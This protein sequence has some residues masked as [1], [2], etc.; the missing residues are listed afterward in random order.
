MKYRG[1]AMIIRTK[2][3][4]MLLLLTGKED[5]AEN[6]LMWKVNSTKKM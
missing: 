6:W 2:S 5:N 4:K 3:Y 1:H